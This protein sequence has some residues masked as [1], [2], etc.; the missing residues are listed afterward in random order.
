MLNNQLKIKFLARSHTLLGLFAVF[1]FYISTYF[2]SIT[3]F[4]PYLNSWEL[5]SRHYSQEVKYEHIID[6]QLNKIIKENR[7]NPTNIE[8][9]LPS[10]RDDTIKISSENQNSIYLNPY[11]KELLETNNEYPIISELFNKFHTGDNIPIIGMKSM[12]VSSIILIFLMISGIYLYILKK[13]TFKDSS[14]Q[15]RNFRFKWHKNFGIILTPYVIVFALTGAFLGFMLSTA[16]PIALSATNYQKSSMSSLVRPILFT[17]KANLEK[18]II[19]SRPMQIKDLYEIASKNYPQLN[20]LKI[21]I[22]NYRLDNSQIMFS[23]YLKDEKARTLSRINPM[24][25][26]LDSKTGVVIEKKELESSHSMKKTLSAF[27]W[28]H[29]QTDD[30]LFL[31]VLFFIFGVVMLICLL[32]GYL[33]WAEKKLKEDNNYFDILN[34]FSLAL[35]LG[36][37]PSSAFLIVMYWI[38]PNN[39]FDRIIW[40]E[41]SFYVAWSFYLFYCFKEDSIKKILKM[42]FISSSILFLLSCFLHEIHLDIF[43]FELLQLGLIRQFFIDFSLILLAIFFYVL[44]KKVDKVKYFE[45]FEERVK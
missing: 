6:L 21:N 34:R 38:I 30:G 39:I 9:Q 17:K 37:I 28:L 24:H 4:L 12:G 41:G 25:I 42:I 33:L 43:L 26:V 36:I 20:I 44:Y 45:K 16:T 18:S 2:G 29:F 14:K 22:Y 10:L 27:Y 40:I 19:T 3:L 8:I 7:L 32:F 5:P 31:R 23:G 1:L 35:M 13:R 11:T 15:N